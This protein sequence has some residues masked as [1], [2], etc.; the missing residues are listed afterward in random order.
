M[1]SE[2][3]DTNPPPQ[4]Y[5]SVPLHIIVHIA[6]RNL[7]SK[8]LRT[9]LTLF[10]VIIGIGAIF[11]LLSFGIGLQN[12][13]TK[14]V[15][16]SRSVK[17]VDISTPNSKIIKLDTASVERIRN[18]PHIEKAGLQFSFP[19]SM[20]QKGSEIDA[21]V[22]GLNE[23]YQSLSEFAVLS[24]RLLKA[25]D[26]DSIVIN[27]AARSA[28][29][30]ADAKGAVDQ[31]LALYVLLN[32]TTAKQQSIEQSF[33]IIGV[34][35]TGAGSEV[36]VPSR[37]F[38]E[39]GV[40]IYAQMK[41]ISDR[42]ENIADLRGQIESLGFE[43]S[44]PSDTIDQ[45]NQ[46]F[47][48]FNF[49][50]VGFGAIGMIVAVLGMFNTLTISLLERTREIGLM[51]A[52]GGRNRDMSKLFIFEAVLLSIVGACIGIMMAVLTGFIVNSFMNNFARNR[53]VNNQFTL[54]ATPAWLVLSLIGFMVFVG[55]LV[56]L[57]PAKRA[58]RIDPI[59]ALRRE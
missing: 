44:S 1:T 5:S 6:W 30:F 43:T 56:A 58:Q 48:L 13:V 55:L 53:G 49:A 18:L 26:T 45:I 8:K 31:S 50:L 22:Y 42:T 11:F 39:V 24:G 3:K 21:V 59:D 10:G 38:E 52:L 29:G 17:S 7:S 33:K 27:D 23:D 20:K 37:I 57:F 51:I 9:F 46:I 2:P 41:V 14:E 4:K 54:F 28:L 25:D 34:I 12:L 47:K 19:G 35:D 32:N 15:V 40:S 16:G 36:L